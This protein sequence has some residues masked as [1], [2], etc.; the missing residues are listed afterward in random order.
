[1]TFLEHMRKANL[2]N[3]TGQL[4]GKMEK[5]KDTTYLMNFSKCMVEQGLG[6]IAK[7]TIY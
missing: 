6:E 4:E 2:E 1:M 3:F 7:T 5:G